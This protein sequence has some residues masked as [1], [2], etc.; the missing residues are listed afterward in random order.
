MRAAHVWFSIEHLLNQAW[1][2]NPD[3][4]KFELELLDTP[5]GHQQPILFR[6]YPMP[7]GA[8]NTSEEAILST[9]VHELLHVLGFLGHNDQSRFPDSIMRDLT[10]L[11]IDHLPGIDGEVLLAAHN[12]FEPGTLP[13]E[14][15]E[16][17]LGR[18]DDTSFHLRGDV[19]LANGSARIRHQFE[20]WSAQPWAFGP[21]PWTN[22]ANKP[23]PGRNGHVVRTS[24]GF[25]AG[26]RGG[27]W[28]S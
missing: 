19:E 11:Y 28:G 3:T 5:R 12:R 15:S 4:E 6:Y 27:W 16:E 9:M 17:N 2:L 20:K 18:W 26:H 8:K 21:K 13:E 10:L 25:Y 23:N 14:L 7:Y 24:P 1:V 22:L